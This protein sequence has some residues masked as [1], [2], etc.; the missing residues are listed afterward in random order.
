MQAMDRMANRDEAFDPMARLK[1]LKP[2]RAAT[3]LRE[4]RVSAG[5][6]MDQ[7]ARALGV[8]KSTY[9]HYEHFYTR[10]ITYHGTGIRR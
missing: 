10:A 7:M 2:G 6:S 4:L 3:I 8:H 9:Q 1:S 5:L